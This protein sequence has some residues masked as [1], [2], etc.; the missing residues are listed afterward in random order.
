[1]LQI[2]KLECEKLSAKMVRNVE[3]CRISSC[4]SK[5]H[6]RDIDQLYNNIVLSLQESGDIIAACDYWM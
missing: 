2:Y 3:K 6:N 5:D 4:T 1:M